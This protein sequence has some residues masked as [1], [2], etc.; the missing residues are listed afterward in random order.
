MFVTKLYICFMRAFFH[1]IPKR[2][3]MI[4][5]RISNELS[6]TKPYL[7]YTVNIGYLDSREKKWNSSFKLN[8]D[9]VLHCNVVMEYSLN[10]WILDRVP[11]I[12]GI[13]DT[14]KLKVRNI[15]YNTLCDIKV[16]MEFLY[17]RYR[18][19]VTFFTINKRNSTYF[20]LI[21]FNLKVWCTW[22]CF[23]WKFSALKLSKKNHL[24]IFIIH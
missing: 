12:W 9:F 11:T 6:A 21:F 14:W 13:S 3:K 23:V 24:I 18:K 4:A 5:Y 17:P 20:Y 2:N 1:A 19:F 16:Q 10:F 7:V 15:S 22:I 8:R